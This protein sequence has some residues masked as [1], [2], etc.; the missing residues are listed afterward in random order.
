M[1]EPVSIA[2]VVGMASFAAPPRRTALSE[3]ANVVTET[4]CKLAYHTEIS[5]SL[6]G[7]KGAALSSLFALADQSSVANW[8]GEDGAPIQPDAVTRTAAFIRALPEGIRMPV[9]GVDPD[10]DVSLD[11]M[12]G[13]NRMFSLSIGRTNR[14]AFAWLIGSDKGHA[15]ARFDGASIPALALERLKSTLNDAPPSLR[16][17]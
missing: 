12:L 5:E 10:G 1:P 9:V 13:R 3:E 14:L 4:T 6:F 7:E 15:V 2:L 11:W 16:A 17:A 8:D